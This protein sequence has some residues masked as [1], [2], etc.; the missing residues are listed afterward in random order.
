MPAAY[1]DESPDDLEDREYPD[2]EDDEEMT[3][4]CPKCGA[5]VFDDADQCPSCGWYLIHDTR[6][7]SGKSIWWIALGLLGI[8]AVILALAFGF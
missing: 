5:E 4:P 6:A 3:I 1:W 7:W 8:I 2:I